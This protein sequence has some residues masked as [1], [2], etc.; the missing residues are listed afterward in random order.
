MSD[1]PKLPKGV[2]IDLLEA[3]SVKKS[4]IIVQVKQEPCWMDPIIS[5]LEKDS[6]LK[7][8]KKPMR[9]DDKFYGMSS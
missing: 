2:F 9:S 4:T 1:Y 5:F 3:P 6:L 8:Q 7:N